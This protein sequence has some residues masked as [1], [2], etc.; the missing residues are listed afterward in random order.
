MGLSL[1]RQRLYHLSAAL[2]LRGCGTILLFPYL[3]F[4]IWAAKNTVWWSFAGITLTTLGYRYILHG[5][6]IWAGDYRDEFP[7]A[8]LLLW[9]LIGLDLLWLAVATSDGV[10]SS[11]E[12]DVAIM[13]ISAVASGFLLL[14][15][16]RDA[17]ELLRRRSERRLSQ[18][19]AAAPGDSLG[20]EATSTRPLALALTA[21]GA[22]LTVL[23]VVVL[24][25]GMIVGFTGWVDSVSHLPS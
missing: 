3:V 5:D 10:L 20:T 18:Q 2:M 19:P 17:R 9:Q 6:R 12:A 24:A 15:I 23:L 22:V 21:V 13:A 4:G 1:D 16:V 14:G 7:P 8:G 11:H 25:G